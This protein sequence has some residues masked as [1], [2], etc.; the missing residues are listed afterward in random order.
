MASKWWLLTTYKSWDDPPRRVLFCEGL[1]FSPQKFTFRICQWEKKT[2][3]KQKKWAEQK[4]H[5]NT[6]F[7]SDV[8]P[9]GN[10]YSRRKKQTTSVQVQSRSVP[11]QRREVKALVMEWTHHHAVHQ[12]AAHVEVPWD[13]NTCGSGKK[14][15]ELKTHDVW[16]TLERKKLSSL[17]LR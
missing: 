13:A 9:W 14:R 8:C 1:Q 15:C 3:L 12:E 4:K 17:K 2:T 7:H 11:L 6:S 5:H 16:E 10:C